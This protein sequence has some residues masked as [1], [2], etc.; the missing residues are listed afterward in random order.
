MMALFNEVVHEVAQQSHDDAENGQ[1]DP[2]LANLRQHR[3]SQPD[4][5]SCDEQRWR[6]LTN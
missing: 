1:E 5:V 3:V 4:A 2:I 6:F